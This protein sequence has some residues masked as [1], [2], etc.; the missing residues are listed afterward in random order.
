VFDQAWIARAIR[1]VNRRVDQLIPAVAKSFAPVVAE[2]Q[3]TVIATVEA[4]YS[5]T[6][7]MLAAIASP[8][9]ISPTTVTASGQVLGDTG[10]FPGGV[11]SVG[12][13]NL[14]LTYGGPYSSQYIHQD[15]NM[16]YVPSSRRFKQDIE[17]MEIDIAVL[18]QLRLVS[19]RYIEAV[20][21]LGDDAAVEVGLIA[22]EV[23][24]LGLKWLVDYD[25]EGKP[26]GIKYDRLALLFIPW[27]QSIENRLAA[28]EG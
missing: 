12:V 23:D 5:T 22:E 11:N 2:I 19:F 8:G 9:A 20:K 1:D 18:Q 24:A 4:T 21:N 27:A 13:Y 14:L 3:A 7:Q 17:T 28:L 26:F 6:A 15:G 25:T 10:K 16:G